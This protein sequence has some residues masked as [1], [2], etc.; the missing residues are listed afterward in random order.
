MLRG[1]RLS[2]GTEFG[3][4]KMG[5]TDL[6]PNHDDLPLIFRRSSCLAEA[7]VIVFC[8]CLLNAYIGTTKKIFI[9]RE[10]S[11]SNQL[12]F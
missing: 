11:F 5:T 8:L 12:S 3:D 10:N 1:S 6:E 4:R 9:T 2:K 7:A